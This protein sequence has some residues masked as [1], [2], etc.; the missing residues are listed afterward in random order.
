MESFIYERM[1]TY[2]E[3][4]WWFLARREILAAVVHNWAPAGARSIDGVT[5]G[6]SLSG[7]G[8]DYADGTTALRHV[9]LEARVGQVTALVGPAGAGKTTLAQL[10]CG[11]L[12][13]TRGRVELDGVDLRA[14]E[15]D[16]LRRNIAF[17]FQETAF[18][19]DGAEANIRLGRPEASDSEVRRATRTVA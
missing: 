17:V 15:P 5:R 12:E 16:A 4:H 18:F 3:S 14:I 10:M 7:V 8:F 9:Y 13:P 1:R 2:E 11:Y 6:V 19:D